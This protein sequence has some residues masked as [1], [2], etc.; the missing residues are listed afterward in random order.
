MPSLALA[1]WKDPH[2]RGSDGAERAGF[3]PAMEREPHT[4]LAG[5]CLQPLGH[6]SRGSG[7]CRA[8]AST[9]GPASISAA[10]LG[11]VAERLN[12]LVLKTSVRRPLTAGSN[13]APSAPHGR[14]P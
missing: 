3:E 8:W 11:G 1:R 12:A 2:P 10:S 14:R 6:L 13:P 5:E 9:R 4:R 7:Q